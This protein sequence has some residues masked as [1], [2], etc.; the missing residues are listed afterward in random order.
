MIEAMI[1]DG[2]VFDVARAAALTDELIAAQAEHLPRFA[3]A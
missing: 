3:T 2:A 1:A